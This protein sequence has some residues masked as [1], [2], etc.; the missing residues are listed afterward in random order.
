M[1]VMDEFR[2]EREAI[3]N[4]PLNKKMK[5]I[6]DYYKLQIIIAVVASACIIAGIYYASTNKT[7]VL[8]GIFLNCYT[9]DNEYTADNIE[10]EFLTEQKIDTDE[11]MVEFVTDLT[12]EMESD[13]F[14]AVDDNSTKQTLAVYSSSKLLD[15]IAGSADDLTE[16][17]YKGYFVDLSEALSD[18]E[19]KMYEPYFLYLD[20]DVYE[21]RKE[22]LDNGGDASSIQIPDCTDKDS[23][24][25]PIPVLI[26]MNQSKKLTKAYNGSVDNVVLGIAGNS[27]NMENTRALIEYLLNN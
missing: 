13:S 14:L 6:W 1:A 8:N 11:Y 24:K 27:P 21:Q 12:Y 18:E 17:A 19:Y 23:M 3:K 2:E 22:I 15:F 16:L 25:E 5:Y 9:V 20:M 7:T 26:D 10:E 4:A